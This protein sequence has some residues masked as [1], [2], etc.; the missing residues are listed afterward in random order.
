MSEDYDCDT[1]HDTGYIC[2]Q[3]READGECTCDD[4]DD[5][6]ELI[7]CPDC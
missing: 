7:A 2:E 4:A 1:C 5:G 3:C 6:P